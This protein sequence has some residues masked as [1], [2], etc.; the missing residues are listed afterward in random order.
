MGPELLLLD[1]IMTSLNPK[2]LDEMLLEIKKLKE[3]GITIIAIEHVMKAIME[4]SERI[5][6]LH[7]GKKIAE[8]K[9]EEIVRNPQVIE[10][11]LGSKYKMEE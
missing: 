2:E 6:V 9:P 10:A 1:E 7:L 3:K 11:Y 5:V 4:I 8:G